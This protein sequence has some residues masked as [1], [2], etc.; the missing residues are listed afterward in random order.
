MIILAGMVILLFMGVI[1]FAIAG[2]KEKEGNENNQEHVFKHIYVYLIL[3]STLMMMIGGSIGVFMSVADYVAPSVYHQ[4]FEEYAVFKKE[5]EGKI[6]LETD[7]EKLKENYEEKVLFEE[8]RAKER[9]LNG[10]IK[11]SAWIFIPFPIFLAFHRSIRKKKKE[12]IK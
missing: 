9:A 10:I 7:S 2:A 1:A 11:S 12:K 8:N 6:G 3:F 4:S 5:S